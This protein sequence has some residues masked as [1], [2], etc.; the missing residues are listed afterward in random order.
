MIKGLSLE[1]HGLRTDRI[2]ADVDVLVEPGKTVEFVKMLE[3]EGWIERATPFGATRMTTHSV[4]LVRNGWPTDLDVHHQFPGLLVGPEKAFEALWGN[5]Q[6]AAAAGTATWV[7]DRSS[8]IVLWA[9]HSLRDGGKEPRHRAELERLV[10][11]VLPILTAGERDQLGHRIVE[12][13]ADHV[14]REVPELA[15]LI[16]EG[17]GTPD[18]EASASWHRKVRQ[19]QDVT[20]WLQVLREATLLERPAVVWRAVWPSAHDLR[21]L[22][23]ELVDTPV[24]RARSRFRRIA[25]LVN[26]FLARS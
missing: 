15:G 8:A 22:D 4:T 18:A 5:R 9:I 11:E 20:P 16:G 10:G 14:L 3:S 21:L 19:A 17:E 24:G 6:A 2:A 13:G 1:F 26:R 25:R 12:L 7:P 23:E